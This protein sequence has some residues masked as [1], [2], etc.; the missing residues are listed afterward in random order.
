MTDQDATAKTAAAQRFRR[1]VARLSAAVWL[2]AAVLVFTVLLGLSAERPEEAVGPD[3]FDFLG[4]AYHLVTHGVYQQSIRAEADHP[5]LGREPGYALFLAGLMMLE[6]TFGSFAPDCL[7]EARDCDDL[8][9]TPQWANAFLAAAAGGLIFL[10]ARL[11]FTGLLAACVAGG[12]IWLNFEAY[13]GLFF[14]ISDYLALF[15]VALT[16]YTAVRSWHSRSRFGWLLVGLFAAA[17]S[18]TKAVYLYCFL[19]LAAVA[20]AVALLRSAQ[21]RTILASLLLAGSVYAA[22]V[23]GWMARNYAVGDSFAITLSRG[24]IALSTR[25][26]FNEMTPE[27]YAAAFVYWTR[28]FGDDLAKSLFDEATWRPFHLATPDGFY[29]TGQ[30]GYGT[31]VEALMADQGLGRIAA[32]QLIDRDLRSAILGNLP[33]HAVTTLP[34]F[35]RGIWI[36]EFIVLSLPALVLLLVSALRRLDWPLLFALSP[37]V[38]SLLFYALFSL[39]I[40]RYQITALPALALASGW[41]ALAL[42]ARWRE[43]RNRKAAISP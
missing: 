43:T 40:P 10:A 11:L 14:V 26:V 41:L 28:G 13:D 30:L 21:R 35:Y 25:V 9:R 29:L 2:S 3:S 31:R 22:L 27:Q 18:L 33:V 23:G 5:S 4:G 8:Y 37:G 38:F 1:I 19:P 36:D 16:I 15:L 6:P 7:T 20:L 39:N 12:H 42:R 34:V 32:E 17:L 24:G